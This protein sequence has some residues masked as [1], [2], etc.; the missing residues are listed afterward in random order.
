MGRRTLT[1][2]ELTFH[3]KFVQTPASFPPADLDGDDLA[4]LFEVWAKGLSVT[5][6]RDP[7]RQN[8]V[9]VSAV[10]RF[11]AR[12]IVVELTV[13]SYGEAGPVIDS[14]SGTTVFEL[15]DTQAPTGENRAV[16]MVPERGESAYYLSEE[17]TRGSAGGRLLRLFKKH[18][19]AYTS[20]ITMRTETVSESEAWS[21][22]AALKE[23]ELRLKSRSA[24][25]ADGPHVEVGTLSYIARPPRRQVFPRSL[26][27][28][29]GTDRS[30]ARQVVGVSDAPEDAD[31]YVTLERENRQKKFL[32]GTGGAPA[33]R[34][35]LND[36]SQP[37]L[38]VTDL[39]ATCAEKVSDLTAR[40]G[41]VGW[42]PSWSTP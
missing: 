8:W 21:S 28:R 24:D 39:V 36:A 29:L 5:D 25:I 9:E 30:I 16:L 27:T 41:G 37:P 22:E 40:T 18:F 19:S 34:E 23:V 38:T 3:Q 7:D 4:D 6:T 20:T 15:T 14:S 10:Q 2:S 33:I 13:G 12:V 11:A 42:D 32:V 1:V 17:S 35:V 31:V 26:L